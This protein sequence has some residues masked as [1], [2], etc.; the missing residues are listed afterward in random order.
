MYKFHLVGI[1]NNYGDRGYL[2]E[3]LNGPKVN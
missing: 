1:P 3:A 2:Y